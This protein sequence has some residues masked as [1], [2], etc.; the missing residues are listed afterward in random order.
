M[1]VANQHEQFPEYE[2]V[3]ICLTVSTGFLRTISSRRSFEPENTKN[4]TIELQNAFFESS[5]ISITCIC[6]TLLHSLDSIYL[7]IFYYYIR[8]TVGNQI[9]T[10]RSWAALF[11]TFTFIRV[12]DIIAF[13]TFTSIRSDPREQFYENETNFYPY[14]CCDRDDVIC[15]HRYSS[16]RFQ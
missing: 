2:G 13:A 16:G 5:E 7:S 6:Y 9:W 14:T 1:V 4:S 3:R 10:A 15:Q 8:Y 11:G 12:H